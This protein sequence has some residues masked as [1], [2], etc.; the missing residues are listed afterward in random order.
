MSNCPCW[1]TRFLSFFLSVTYPK[2]N[3]GSWHFSTQ[4]SPLL[5]KK[6]SVMCKRIFDGEV[7][8]GLLYYRKDFF[9]ISY[10]GTEKSI[11]MYLRWSSIRQT[12]G[13]YSLLR[14]Y[15]LYHLTGP[16]MPVV[17]CS[18]FQSKGQILI[19]KWY[20]ILLNPMINRSN[21]SWRT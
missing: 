15:S 10:P 2:K 5:R 14:D 8:D 16:I 4:K 3:M 13:Q 9:L 18:Q 12:W 6:L 20:S 19:K 21:W 17:D 1:C 7:P 11:S